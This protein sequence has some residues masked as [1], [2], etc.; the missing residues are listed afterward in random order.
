LA[1]GRNE[2]ASDATNFHSQYTLFSKLMAH[3]ELLGEDPAFSDFLNNFSEKPL[4]KL[5][6]IDHDTRE[7]F[8]LSP[9][10][11]QQMAD[12]T[13]EIDNIRIQIEAVVPLIEINPDDFSAL[14]QKNDLDN[15]LQTKEAALNQIYANLAE[16]RKNAAY[17]LL[18]TNAQI[19]TEDPYE[20]N[21]KTLHRIYLATI[22]SNHAYFS[23]QEKDEIY[24]IAIQCPESAG[25]AVYRARALWQLIY[26]QPMNVTCDGNAQRDV[27]TTTKPTLI[28]VLVQPNPAN[29]MVTFVWNASSVEEKYNLR[30]SDNLGKTAINQSVNADKGNVVINTSKLS[31]GLYFYTLL[32]AKNAIISACKFQIIH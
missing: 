11:S 20:A 2:I 8:K 25:P 27:P 32:D 29:D 9:E 4:G 12:L 13:T 26:Q 28:P 6:K 5:Y 14:G 19:E 23:E 1:I 22:A 18:Q 7:I 24:Q 31:N 15:K 10:I 3:P 21:E 17:D 16:I 30:I